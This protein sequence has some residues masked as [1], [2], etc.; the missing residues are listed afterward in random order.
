MTHWYQTYIVPKLLN[1]EMYSK[2]L[3]DTREE[4]LVNATGIVLEIGIGPGY[5][6]AHYK[7][8]E[9][10]YALDPSEGLIKI[11]KTR[12]TALSYPVEFLESSAEAILLP[13]HSIDTVVSTWTLCSV[14][15]LPQVLKEISR[16]LK[17][18]GKFIF[19]DHGV[20]PLKITHIIQT[21][22]TFLT[23]HFTGNC[24]YDRNIKEMI[25]QA[26]FSFE[27][28]DCSQEKSKPLIYNYIGIAKR[29]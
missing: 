16:V 9:K 29:A 21:C 11:A 8:I 20:S 18:T 2:D 15:D 24:H 25:V 19:A 27:K 23:K 12:A 14:T 22:F 1:Y 17:P 7:Q 5:N 4:V 10:L 26:G 13:N 28:I 6:F 3:E